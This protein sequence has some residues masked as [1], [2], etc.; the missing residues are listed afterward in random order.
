MKITLAKNSGFCS[1][2]RRAVHAAMN[3][4]GANTYV[5]G[6]IIH[7][8][9]VIDAIEER[10]VKQVQALDEVPDGAK[11]IFRSH[12]VPESVYK[13]AAA[14]NIE[15][16]DCTCPFV[17][18]TQRIVSEKHA[19]G[20]AIVIVG[21]PTHPEVV[22]L[23]GWCGN[24]AYVLSSENAVLPPLEKKEVCVVCQTTF[25]VEKF[26]KIIENIKKQR[27]KTVDVFK[28]ICYTT[29]GR[30]KEA[31]EI[32]ADSDAVLVVGGL[33]SSN[34]NKLYEVASRKCAHVFRLAN[35][36]DFDYVRP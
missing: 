6:E 9:E 31:E 4:D 36:R 25:S 19:E 16:L 14:R 3:A 24:S 1:G 32:A 29:I 11:V 5:L 22:G 26:E 17:K 21:E 23:Q 15:V 28:T 8:K 20:K 30:Q 18:K 33:N 34:T 12:G 2:V 10:G 35:A 13:D 27:E 7:N